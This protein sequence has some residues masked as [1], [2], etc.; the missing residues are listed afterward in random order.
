MRIF[1]KNEEN[2]NRKMIIAIR[3]NKHDDR[4]HNSNHTINDNSL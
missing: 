2:T 3:K 4:K 1:L